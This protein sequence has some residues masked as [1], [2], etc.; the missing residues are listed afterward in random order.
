MRARRLPLLGVAFTLLGIGAGLALP[1]IT[2]DAYPTTYRR[3]DVPYTASSITAGSALY[4]EHCVACHGR[5]GR[6]DGPAAFAL[7]RPPADLRA[8]HTAHHTAGDLYWWITNGIPAGGM[9]A[10]GDRIATEERWDLVN[11]VRALGDAEAARTLS[12]AIEPGRARI[13]APDFTYAVV[14]GVSHTLR[15]HRGRRIVVLVIYSL[16]ASR[17]RLAELATAYSTLSTLGVEV[18]AVPA[19]AAPNPI[20]ALALPTPALFPVVADGAPDIVTAYALFGRAP[21]AEF[22]ID[23]QGYL[24]ARW[25]SD[26]T[27]PSLNTVLA[28]VQELNTEKVIAPLPSEH[29]H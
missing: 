22:L 1:P 9:P 24:R 14:P 18:L 13:V 5:D 2:V 25:L 16:P 8:A 28:E 7:P 26:G 15:E 20:H 6:G 29:V 4:A 21:H 3:P 19:D 11:V 10:F 23:R 27:T 12:G 17:P